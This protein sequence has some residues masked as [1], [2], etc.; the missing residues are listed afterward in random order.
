MVGMTP[1]ILEWVLNIDRGIVLLTGVKWVQ[2]YVVKHP[3]LFLLVSHTR[4][5]TGEDLKPHTVGVLCFKSLP[6]PRH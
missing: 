3:H 6:I 2:F 5:Y 4:V 1:S